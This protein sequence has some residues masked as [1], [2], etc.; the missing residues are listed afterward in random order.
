MPHYLI[1]NSTWHGCFCSTFDSDQGAKFY[2]HCERERQKI[3]K[4]AKFEGHILEI[5]NYGSTKSENFADVC[6]LEAS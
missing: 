5:S 3:D 4:M 2:G 1:L 6:I